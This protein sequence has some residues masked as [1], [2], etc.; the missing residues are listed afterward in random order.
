M[1][2][3]RKQLFW[4]QGLF[5][6]P[7]HFQRMDSYHARER[8]LLR[9]TATP[10]FWGLVNFAVNETLLANDTFEIESC[11]L[12]MRDGIVLNFP[13]N[14]TLS[15]R[16]FASAWT[17]RLSPFKIYIGVKNINQHSGNVTIVSDYNES[18]SVTTRFLSLSEP[19]DVTDSHQDGP[20]A[21]IKSIMY[22]AK[23][24]WES[25]I[26]DLRDYALTPVAQLVR[27]GEAT[28][29]SPDFT[30][31]SLHISAS[32]ALLTR[33]KLIREELAS[34]V[35]QMEEYKTPFGAESIE[36]DGRSIPYRLLLQ[37]IS[38]YVPLLFHYMESRDIHP[39]H[40][41]GTLKQIVGGISIVSDRINC[42]GETED[43]TSLLPRY[44]HNEIGKCFRAAH[45]LIIQ[46]LNEIT[47][48]AE[49]LIKMEKTEDDKFK[50]DEISG[51]LFAARNIFY[52]VVRTAA[53][54]EEWIDL[55]MSYAKLGSIDQV[56]HFMQHS[57]PGLGLRHLRVQPEGLPKRPNANYFLIDK[58]D[59]SWKVVESQK[60]IVM[61]WNDAPEDTK[62][63]LIVL[64]K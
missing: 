31:P 22:V 43:G 42:F 53:P 17:D 25:E 12:I 6:Q 28:L 16:S 30:P 52:L 34:R 26:D 2:R 3:K 32:S 11:E 44:N 9:K 41:Y 33:L 59:S 47:V 10:H 13:E 8:Y 55:F 45:E 51:D 58:N 15:S 48:G 18:E 23:I 60:N 54:L 27:D 61:Y 62:V 24:F 5:L 14:A 21:K 1:D 63:E 56:E 35:A 19:D 46:L 49:S 20:E 29:L 50:A 64:R 37:T 38:Q 40:I 36:I 39:W 57:L 4:H 7:Q